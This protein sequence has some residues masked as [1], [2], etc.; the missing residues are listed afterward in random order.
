MIRM[1]RYRFVIFDEVTVVQEIIFK[2]IEVV[3]YIVDREF[4]N[5]IE[6]WLTLLEFKD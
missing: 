2:V 3:R 5:G 1:V 6:N 4:E